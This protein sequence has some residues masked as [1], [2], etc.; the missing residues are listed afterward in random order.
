[1]KHLKYIPLALISGFLLVAVAFSILWNP[2]TIMQIET[3]SLDSLAIGKDKSDYNGDSVTITGRVVAPPQVTINGVQKS[4]LRGTSSWQCYLQ[5]TS[6][7]LWGGIVVRQASRFTNTF[8][9]NIDTGN[10]ITLKGIVQEFWSTTAPVGFQGSGWLTQIQLDTLNG[11]ITIN[12]LGGSRPA[13]KQVNITDFATGDVL[14]GGTINYVGGEKYEGMYVE[15]RNVTVGTG[16][17]NRQ[18]W[19]IVDAAGNK[20]YMRDFSNFFSTSPSP[21]DTLRPWTHPVAGTVVNYIRGVIINCNNEGAFGNQ[22]PYAIVPIYP[23]DLSTGSVPPAL[24]NPAKSPAIPTPADSV[25]VSAT[26]TSPTTLTN[27]SLLWRSGGTGAYQSKAM[28]NLA[29]NIYA[30]KLPP[31]PANTLVEYFLSASNSGGLTRFLPADTSNSKLFYVVKSTDSLSIQEV[32]YCPNN[33]GHSGYEGGIVRGIEGIVTADTSD[34]RFYSHLSTGGTL[35]APARVTLQNGQ[36]PFSGIWIFGDPTN[37]I[38]RGQRVRV[39]GVV[40]YNFGM[41]RINV[42]S[43]SDITVISSGNTLPTPQIL[44]GAALANAFHGGDT[45]IK[46]WES[47][48]VKMAT[49]VSIT[50]INANSGSACTSHQTYSD[51]VFRRNYGDILVRDNSGI[52]ARVTI[53]GGNH[54]FTNNWAADSAGRTLLTQND[55]ISFVQ[56][57]LYYSYSNYKIQPRR[58]TD[59][60][61]LT[62]VGITHFEQTVNTYKLSQNYPNPFNPTTKINFSIPTNGMV[63]LKIYDILGREVSTLVNAQSQAGTYIVDFNAS[64]LS[65]GVYFYRLYVNGNDGSKFFD[66]KK[67]LLIK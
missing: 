49:P 31:Y 23:N 19:S 51:T 47:V 18:P 43:A 11:P 21:A 3:K 56:G 39:K 41:I 63:T 7:A 61:T 5:D 28:P 55:S 27:V 48:L 44:T 36:G 10:I 53:P 34:I 59:W 45:A 40:E 38:L 58:N 30:A 57:V 26:I 32:Q 54:T 8:L 42:S 14:N 67:M 13:P 25:Q 4:L 22:L 1:M 64:E 35:T 6:G 60:G 2:R 37:T 9:Q 20:L 16:V 17:A 46:K 52:E 24:S 12:S 65:S 33:G 15:I 29:G 50:C 66:V 62:P